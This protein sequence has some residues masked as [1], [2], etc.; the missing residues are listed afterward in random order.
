[1]AHAVDQCG[2]LSGFVWTQLTDV[3]QEINGLLSFDR[4]PKLPLP[5]LREIFTGI[6]NR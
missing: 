2:A 5:L 1:M 4:R 6:G 3:Q